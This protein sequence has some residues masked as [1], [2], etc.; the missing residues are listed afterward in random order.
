[1]DN[2]FKYAGYAGL[3]GVGMVLLAHVH[4]LLAG[5]W[6]AVGL[7]TAVRWIRA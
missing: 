7:I 3:F 2:P 6:A 4:P 5:T 1:M